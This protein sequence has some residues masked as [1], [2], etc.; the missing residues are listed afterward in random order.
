MSQNNETLYHTFTKTSKTRMLLSIDI[1]LPTFSVDFDRPLGNCI[2]NYSWLRDNCHVLG[3]NAASSGNSLP[4]F[5]DNLS[6]PS[7]G[8]LDP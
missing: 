8:V 6:V 2:E 1:T 5:R 3:Y 4:T 7:S